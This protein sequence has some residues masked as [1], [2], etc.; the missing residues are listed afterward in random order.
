[1]LRIQNAQG[2][3]AY[4]GIA[5]NERNDAFEFNVALQEFKSQ[6]EREKEGSSGSGLAVATSNFR[7]LA[8]G[9]G[10]KIKINVSR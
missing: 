8:G 3:H 5:F 4:I 2:K 7:D 1:V 9:N 10:E 6:N